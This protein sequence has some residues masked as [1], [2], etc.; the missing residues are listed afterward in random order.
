MEDK[1]G[2]KTVLHQRLT[3]GQIEIYIALLLS[4]AYD[5]RAHVVRIEL[6]PCR[7]ADIEIVH[8]REAGTDDRRVGTSLVGTVKPVM[9]YACIRHNPSPVHRLHGSAGLQAYGP[10]V[11]G[12]H[13][14]IKGHARLLRIG[15]PD[16]LADIRTT[17]EETCERHYVLAPEM[18]SVA[19][20]G[21]MD[22]LG[23]D[24]GITGLLRIVI[25]VS[26]IR[27]K[28]PYSRSRNAV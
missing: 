18:L 24:I 16:A 5:A 23:T 14:G 27:L 15:G 6:Q 28:L 10:V 22:V 26:Y 1:R 21:R 8:H 9:V 20:F 13:K 3:Y 7:P 4:L 11:S 12:I 25:L 19:D 17:A 2:G